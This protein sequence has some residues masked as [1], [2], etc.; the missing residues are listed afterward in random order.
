MQFQLDSQLRDARKYAE[1]RGVALIGAFPVSVH[2]RGADAWLQ[3]ELVADNR[4][5]VLADPFFFSLLTVPALGMH[6][7]L[8]YQ[9]G[10]LSAVA[11]LQCRNGKHK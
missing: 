5:R 9:A 11:A 1:M 8:V 4:P 7:R 6:L 2:A 3:P 10:C